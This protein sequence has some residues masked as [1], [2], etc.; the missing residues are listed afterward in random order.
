MHGSL[1][2]RPPTGVSYVQCAYTLHFCPDREAR[3]PFSPLHDPAVSEWVQFAGVPE[4]VAVVHS[5]RLPV[6][7]PL[8][9]VVDA[10]SL[11]TPLRV[12][13]FFALGAAAR[14]EPPFPGPRAVARR[15]AAMAA[16][17]ADGRCARLLFRTDYARRMFIDHLSCGVHRPEIVEMLAAKSEVV[18]PAVPATAPHA[19]STGRVCVLYMGRTAQ[20]KGAAVAAEVFVRLRERHGS[21]VRLVFLGP[22]PAELVGRLVAAGVELVPVLPRTDYL[23]RLRRADVFLS[24][25]AFESFGMGL[26]EA[27]AAGLAVVC[28]AGP[29]MEHIDELFA[30]GENALFVRDTIPQA[31]RV[32]DFTAAASALI[33]DESLR[34]HLSMNNHALT[35]R[36]KLS[37]RR[38][39]ERLGAV[40]AQAVA[41]GDG[42]V[43]DADAYPA[44]SDRPVTTWAEEVCHWAGRHC[45]AR[46]GGRVVAR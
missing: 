11:M 14:G 40:Y 43:G 30:D 41:L 46:L 29:G 27:A 28:P 36:G 2:A 8:P 6:R 22:C 34:R 39:D 4:G 35:S 45:A 23:E 3:R 10:D 5:S 15:E 33:E 42:P 12:G 18:H 38:R 31:R 26:L 19:R 44:E 17:Y 24:P 32:A 21:T 25:T 37:V 1:L 7:S 9:W 16:R 20:D 13:R